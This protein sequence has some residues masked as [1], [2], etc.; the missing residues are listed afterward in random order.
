[1]LLNNHENPS[2]FIF[3]AAASIPVVIPAINLHILTVASIPAA[4][5]QRLLVAQAPPATIEPLSFLPLAAASI[6]AAISAIPQPLQPRFSFLLIPFQAI[7]TIAFEPQAFPPILLL[8]LLNP[9][10]HSHNHK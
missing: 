8:K 2:S 3:L 6:P 1:M 5:N 9:H 10:S 4:V 7:N